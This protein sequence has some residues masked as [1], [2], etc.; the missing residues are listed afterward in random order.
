MKKTKRIEKH[1]LDELKQGLIVLLLILN[2]SHY[3]AQSNLA[4]PP[5]YISFEAGKVLAKSQEVVSKIQ[6]SVEKNDLT[7]LTEARLRELERQLEARNKVVY[8]SVISKKNLLLELS[9]KRSE[10]ILLQDVS[11]IDEIIRIREENLKNAQAQFF[12]ALSNQSLQGVY[13]GIRRFSP[14]VFRQ[15]EFESDIR[16]Q[17]SPLAVK[18]IVGVYVNSITEVHNKKLI[19]E[20]ISTESMGNYEQNAPYSIKN[21]AAGYYIEVSKAIVSPLKSI[22]SGTIDRSA[23]QSS[24]QVMV[25]NAQNADYEAYLK[26]FQ[27]SEAEMTEI[28]TKVNDYLNDV[29]SHNNKVKIDLA[30]IEA[31][32]NSIIANAEK[33]LE[34]A[35]KVKAERTTRVRKAL[36]EFR[37]AEQPNNTMAE[38]SSIVSFLADKEK[39]LQ[40]EIVMW[41]EKELTKFLT[42]EISVQGD[43]D[44]ILGDGIITFSNNQIAGAKVIESLYEYNEVVKGKLTDSF[45]KI[46][47][48][49]SR[50]PV[51]VYAYFAN[52]AN[53]YKVLVAVRYKIL[54]EN[55]SEKD[56]F[57]DSG[58]AK[59][60]ELE[61]QEENFDDLSLSHAGSDNI[62]TPSVNWPQSIQ[63]LVKSMIFVKGGYVKY[64][65]FSGNEFECNS[66]GLNYFDLY[67]TDYHLGQYEVTQQQ[68]FDIMGTTP[69][70]KKNCPNCPVT[71]ISEKEIFDFIQKLNKLTGCE[72]RLPNFF[73]WEYVLTEKYT[74][75]PPIK[76]FERIYFMDGYKLQLTEKEKLDLEYLWMRGGFKNS[77]MEW[78]NKQTF[79]EPVNSHA[80][81]RLGFYN[82]FGNAAEFVAASKGLKNHFGRYGYLDIEERMKSG[83]NYDKKYILNVMMDKE[84]HVTNRKQKNLLPLFFGLGMYWQET[85]GNIAGFNYYPNGNG[86]GFRLVHSNKLSNGELISF[87]EEISEIDYNRIIDQYCT[88]NKSKFILF[89]DS[90]ERRIE[91]ISIDRQLSEERLAEEK[92][93]K[94]EFEKIYKCII[95]NSNLT[96]NYNNY[97]KKLEVYFTFDVPDIVSEINFTMRINYL[98]ITLSSGEVQRYNMSNLSNTTQ[99]LNARNSKARISF[100]LTIS[101]SE[102]YSISYINYSFW[103]YDQTDR[104]N[105]SIP[106]LVE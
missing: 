28:T 33:E 9:Q 104:K 77:I 88:V 100:P 3:M 12:Q 14:G 105:N 24:N 96:Y 11:K 90:I 50:T 49:A 26:S 55:G 25:F 15:A 98:D 89:I 38:I 83:Q 34:E 73:E 87:K 85:R 8:D 92:R 59:D 29:A 97:E 64:G 78:P 54:P 58:Q 18:D 41:K 76:K 67:L 82:M 13:I 60:N 61:P 45:V 4:L 79:I 46:K 65:C 95:Y 62:F 70:L 31:R 91:Q 20:K 1:L 93:R 52:T 80:P 7:F 63:E 42:P 32:Q 30:Q 48:N 57:G 106:V 51:E 74:S 2:P 94:E 5:G 37:L 68:W 44:Q 102:S 19:N 103:A 10:F 53:G 40:N 23:N 56:D 21:N 84:N 6:S 75:F 99:V 47:I 39:V 43:Y 71:N 35:R 72:F 22:V 66:K 36:R 101:A 17:I 81:N 69:S 27:L 86:T 16:S